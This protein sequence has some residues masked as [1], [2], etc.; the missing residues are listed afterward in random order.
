[1]YVCMY[2][3]TILRGS[4]HYLHLGSSDAGAV[5][6]YMDAGC[7]TMAPI[8]QAGVSA[9]L[10]HAAYWHCVAIGLS[11]LHTGEPCCGVDGLMAV[12]SGLSVLEHSPLAYVLEPTANV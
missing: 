1:M 2:V 9:A 6:R 12:L 5:C 11:I 7:I 8:E 10:L 3:H 4:R